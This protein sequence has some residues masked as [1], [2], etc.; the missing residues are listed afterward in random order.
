MLYYVY[1]AL[2]KITDRILFSKTYPANLND[3]FF[4]TMASVELIG[5]FFFRSRET[6]ALLPRSLLVTCTCFFM[7]VTL[8]AYGYYE[9]GFRTMWCFIAG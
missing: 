5:I 6:L 2:A 9:L 3:D 4:G 8:T 1:V 7:Y